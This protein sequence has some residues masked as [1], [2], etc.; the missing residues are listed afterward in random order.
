MYGLY[1][2]PRATLS[3]HC[4]VASNVH[5]YLV[6]WLCVNSLLSFNNWYMIYMHSYPTIPV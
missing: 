4:Y 5:Y 6:K 3:I 1:I 2:T